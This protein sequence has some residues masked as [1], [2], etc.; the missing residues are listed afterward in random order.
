MGRPPG[1]L[2]R[3][4]VRQG[5]TGGG[6]RTHTG[7]EGPAEFKS[8]ASTIPPLRH[9]DGSDREDTALYRTARGKYTTHRKGR[10][11]AAHCAGH[12]SLAQLR[13]ERGPHPPTVR[14]C[15]SRSPGKHTA[16][17]SENGCGRCPDW[18]PPACSLRRRDRHST[19]TTTTARRR[20]DT[21]VVDPVH[22]ISK[23]DIHDEVDLPS[24]VPWA[25]ATGC[26]KSDR[27]SLTA[28]ALVPG[29]YLC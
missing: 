15:E 14:I 26:C 28:K 22:L 23:H 27:S 8:A 17:V 24:P 18:A 4:D 7:Q 21:Q 13:W 11:D 3:Y 29:Q 1:E 9:G 19:K 5:G 16:R 20:R 10:Q 6:N 12:A 25:R 2:L